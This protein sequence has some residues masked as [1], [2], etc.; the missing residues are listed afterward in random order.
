MI[1]GNSEF[2]HPIV[3]KQD[4][5][6][7]LE[8]CSQLARWEIEQ[9]SQITPDQ[10]DAYFGP[11]IHGDDVVTL[12]DV[13]HFISRLVGPIKSNNPEYLLS[14]FVLEKARLVE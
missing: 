3:H 12:G 5:I 6:D 11:V 2:T 10:Y 8:V 13:G 1:S 7:A 14:L 9:G 4:A